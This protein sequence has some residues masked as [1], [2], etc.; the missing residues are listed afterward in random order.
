M[1]N[2]LTRETDTAGNYYQYWY[3]RFD[4]VTT[5]RDA[6]NQFTDYYY[7]S[8]NRTTTRIYRNGQT[9]QFQYDVLGNMTTMNDPNIG[10]VY[11]YYNKLSQVTTLVCGLGTNRYTY[12]AASRRTRV[13]DPDSNTSRWFYDAASQVTTVRNVT[14]NQY[15]RIWY[16][17]LGQ[18]TQE[19]YPNGVTISYSYDS[20]NRISEIHTWKLTTTY[21]YTTTTTY[22]YST[23]NTFT[24]DFN[25]SDSTNLGNNWTELYGDW[26]VKNNQADIDYNGVA[27]AKYSGSYYS[28]ITIAAD[29]IC[30]SDNASYQNGYLLFYYEESPIFYYAGIDVANQLWRLGKYSSGWS[31]VSTASDTTLSADTGY[32]IRVYARAEYGIGQGEEYE[33]IYATVYLWEGNQWVTKIGETLVDHVSWAQNWWHHAGLIAD[34]GHTRFDNF[35]I[36][37]ELAVET[38]VTVQTTMTTTSTIAQFKYAYDKDGN[39]TRAVD[40]SNNT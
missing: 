19:E 27:I 22:S 4:N 10:M 17:A 15:T 6:K 13:I 21:T 26:S 5:R 35:S 3:D 16:N 23:T 31:D 12:D 39:R 25:R 18:K 11:W 20:S 1:R 29:V 8:L 38:T 33:D 37:Q 2:R 7:D 40:L 24:D 14:Q 32:R 28:Q 30:G 36:N 34:S 9:V